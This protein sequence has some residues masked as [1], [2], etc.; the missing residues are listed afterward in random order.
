[1]SKG[2][3]NQHIQKLIENLPDSI[4]TKTPTRLDV[5]LD[6][7]MFNGSYLI[8]SLFFLKEMEKK[9][10]IAIERISGCS[11]GSI[12][13]L[14][15]FI[16]SLNMFDSLYKLFLSDLKQNYRFQKIKELQFYLKEVIPDDLCKRVN[17]KLFITYYNIHSCKKIVKN[18][19]KNTED[20]IDTI[21]KSCFLPFLIDGNMM[22]KNKYIDGINPYI[23]EKENKNKGDKN[24]G[25]KNKGDK[26]K[27]DKKILYLDLFGYDKIS[28][29]INVKNEKSN[30]HRILV[31]ML[32]IHNFYIKQTSTCICSYMDEWGYLN[33]IHYF[34]KKIIEKCVIYM[35]YIILF[36]KRFIPFEISNHCICKITGKLCFVIYSSLLE[37]VV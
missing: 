19:Y 29:A 11:I 12:C 30:F 25:D 28:Y 1:M 8:G 34:I 5:V 6:G 9:K 15:Y 31:G 24:K 33:N 14:L 36:I 35:I 26:N 13:A 18:V 37:T 32:D 3:I 7:G 21:I 4:K 22:Y 10:Y 17:G 23:F 27:G 20:V 16:D 2:I